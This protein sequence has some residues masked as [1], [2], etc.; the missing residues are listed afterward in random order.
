VKPF[1][2]K[3]CIECHGKD[4]PEKGLSISRLIEGEPDVSKHPAVW[5]KIESALRT[6]GM[7]P[8]DAPQPSLSERRTVAELLAHEYRNMDCSGS[9]DP[10]RATLRRLNRTEYRNTVRDLLGVDFDPAKDFPRDDLGYGFDNMGDVLSLS[11]LHLEKY[12]A[13]AESVAVKAFRAPE[14]VRQPEVPLS[15]VSEPIDSEKTGDRYQGREHV[16]LDNGSVQTSIRLPESGRYVLHVRA[17]ATSGQQA[18][19]AMDIRLDE[20]TMRTFA[21]TASPDDPAWHLHTFFVEA[22]DHVLEIA[23]TNHQKNHSLHLVRT[24]LIGPV[25]VPEDELPVA[26]RRFLVER[27]SLDPGSDNSPSWED[28]ARKALVKLTHHAYR[29]SVA[30]AEVD[31]LLAFVTE[32]REQGASFERSMQTALEAIIVSPSFLFLGGVNR[33][34]GSKEPTRDLD[35]YELASRLSYFLWK[36]MPDQ[37]L[38]DLAASGSLRENLVGQVRRMLSSDKVLAFAHDFGGQWLQTRV[39][40]DVLPDPEV[41]GKFEDSLRRAMIEEVEHFFAEVVRKDSSIV[42]LID[43]DFTYLNETLARHYGIEN[44]SGDHFRRVTL[45]DGKR[46]GVLTLGAVLTVTS[47]PDRTSPVLRGK[48]VLETLL[49]ESPPPPPPDLKIER[50]PEGEKAEVEATLRVRLEHHRKDPLC[51]SCHQHFDPLGFALEHYDGIGRWRSRDTGGQDIDAL[52]KLPDGREFDGISGLKALLRSE[53][54]ELRRTLVEK[55]LT[56]ALG[57]G[58]EFS[59]E[60]TIRDIAT[61]TERSEDKFSG[62]IEGIV[63][64]DAFQKRRTE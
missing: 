49:G 16:F 45:T 27:P 38:F 15:P 12:F 42:S 35:D 14:T 63:Q 57:R 20:R 36:S 1:F 39:L 2:E 22:G 59:D 43:A 58:L 50:I 8:E 17:F 33:S 37:E 26:H 53:L 41:Y 31:R 54:D 9:R 3:H 52:G 19:S 48:W 51:S 5:K 47:S 25:D 18:A 28:A 40:W 56:Y 61:A 44:V 60:C 29:R 46:G 32:G 23:F 7:P 11:P 30:K 6:H 10:G 34:D 55:L 62:L 64:S 4:D 21:V 24:E 13:A